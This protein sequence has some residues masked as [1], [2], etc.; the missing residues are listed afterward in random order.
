MDKVQ[1]N[2]FLRKG[3]L[4]IINLKLY[5]AQEKERQLG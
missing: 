4:N 5:S 3:D 2:L 1:K